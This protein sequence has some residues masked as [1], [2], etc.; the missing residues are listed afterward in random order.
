M[1]GWKDVVA[2]HIAQE[3]FAMQVDCPQAC[4]RLS[5]GASALAD[6]G[7]REV[8]AMIQAFVQARD[9]LGPGGTAT[10]AALFADARTALD[11]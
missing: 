5:A 2:Q 3:G 8:A 1:D 7:K 11:N 4:Q 6:Q 9:A 10:I